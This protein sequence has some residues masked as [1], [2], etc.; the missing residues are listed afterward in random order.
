[1]VSLSTF[2]AVLLL[3]Q[4]PAIAGW[5][6]FVASYTLEGAKT[7]SRFVEP[8]KL[9]Y[10]PSASPVLVAG[11]LLVE[12][13]RLTALEASTGRELWKAAEGEPHYGTPAVF[14]LDGTALAVTAKGTVARV[15]DGTVLAKSVAQGLGGDQSPTPVVQG[16]VVYFAYR[17]CSAVKL[18][19]ADGRIRSD[20]LWEQE[21]PGD[22]ISS[23]ILK[24]GL[25]FVL[26]STTDYR[27]LNAATGEVVLD[28]GV[29]LSPNLYPSLALAGKYLFLGNDK[30]DFVVI[31]ASRQYK[32]V[33][34]NGLPE[35]S[36]ASPAFAG[37]H[38]FLRG[39]RILYC[40]GQ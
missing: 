21:M 30:G 16:G 18:S 9:S 24:D 37:P 4:D 2:V 14:S 25:L 26:P 29:D 31:E 6:G 8:P 15:S 12:G 32:E 5:R 28:K 40:I 13:K 3:A 10:G 20:V 38:L 33:S 17:R 27:V 1:V 34:Q 35:G 39:G 19:W 11:S 22:V 23:P 7:W 36:G